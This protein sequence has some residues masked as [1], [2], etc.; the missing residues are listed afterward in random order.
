MVLVKWGHL[1]FVKWG[2]MPRDRVGAADSA[3][4]LPFAYAADAGFSILPIHKCVFAACAAASRT[5]GGLD[6]LLRITPAGGCPRL[7]A[8]ANKFVH[9]LWKNLI[10]DNVAAVSFRA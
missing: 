10:C 2:K 4:L 7:P 8:T 5:R 1:F 9:I 6:P 3:A